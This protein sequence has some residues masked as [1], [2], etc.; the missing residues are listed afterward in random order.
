MT[1]EIIIKTKLEDIKYTL[2][3]GVYSPKG[4]KY[5]IVFKGNIIAEYEDSRQFELSM[6]CER[7]KVGNEDVK[8]NRK[9]LFKLL[10]G[11]ELLEELKLYDT[12]N[13]KSEDRFDLKSKHRKYINSK[14]WKI[15]RKQKLEEYGYHCD[16]CGSEENLHV[17]HL[18]YDNFEHE[19]MC[20]LQ[21]L[22]RKC[23]SKIHDK[24]G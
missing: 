18:H 16:I 5:F 23:H 12:L 3:D 9:K 15:K 6:C 7:W 19:E 2:E 4:G 24:R 1:T 17:H 22:C 8:T 20:D 13:K 14:E 11:T 21:V 10:C